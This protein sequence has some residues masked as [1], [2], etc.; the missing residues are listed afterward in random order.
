MVD[1]EY[2][3]K[4]YEDYKCKYF[5]KIKA[6][7]MKNGWF[8]L[9]KQWLM[10]CHTEDEGFYGGAAGGGKT[11]YLV[12]EAAS[13]YKI[14]EYKG[15]IFR[16]TYKQLQ[17]VQDKCEQYYPKI[18]KKARYNGTNHCW[19]FSSGAKVYLGAMQYEKDKYKYQGQQ[20]DFIGFDELTHFTMSQYE[21][22]R[23]RNRGKSKET[24]KYMRSTGNPGGI[25]HGWVKQYFI[26]A[27]PPMEP[28]NTDVRVLKPDGTVYSKRITKVFI[29]S[30]VWDNEHMLENNE[31]YVAN[32]ATMNEQDKKALLDGDWD[33][34]SG[35]VFTEFRDNSDGYTTR[36]L[37]HVIPPFKIPAYWNIYR[38]FDWGYSKPFSVGWYAVDTDGNIF[39]IAELYG[40]QRNAAGEA[41]PDTGVK[42]DA[43]RIARKIKEIE[44]YDENIKGHRIVGIGD[45]AIFQEDN[46]SSIAS[47]MAREGVYFQPADHTR[48]P[49]KMQCHYRLAF[50]ENGYAKFAVFNTCRDFIRTIP[51]LV[52]DETHVEDIDTKQEDHI[53]DEWRY[54]MMANPMTAPRRIEKHIPAFDPLNMYENQ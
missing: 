19:T 46:G 52:Y 11:D 24:V 2:L 35:Q 31:N 30:K 42:W 43:G 47:I 38:G 54:I 33:I 34:F 10:M 21:Y 4:V 53:Y 41:I 40:C 26:N 28:I 23:S 17:E 6:K 48:I 7:H 51:T 20:Y 45:P 9:Y 29:P 15:I 8:P 14:P 44:T 1:E 16:R 49:G 25:G 13:Q 27:G 18:D 37:T 50:D 32:L 12:M 36:R 39:R 22:M 5:A 3:K